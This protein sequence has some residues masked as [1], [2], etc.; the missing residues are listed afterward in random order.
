MTLS[1][2]A[3]IAIASSALVT[4]CSKTEPVKTVTPQP[5]Q[6]AKAATSTPDEFAVV[7]GI[8]AKDCASCH[9]DTAEGKTVVVEGQKIK[10]PALSSGHALKHSD[11]DFVK[12]IAKGGEG[13]PSFEKKI[14][15]KD[16]DD[17]VRFIRKEL[18]GGNQ[19][20]A[21]P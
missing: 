7:R 6:S 18:Q 12:Q 21:K 10:A 16:I 4:A 3:I 1:R 8:Y 13:M 19:P 20:A 15:P 5:T 9:G 17:M 2:L 14:S 11:P